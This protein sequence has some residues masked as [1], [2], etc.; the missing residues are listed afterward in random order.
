MLPAIVFVFSRKNVELCAHEI[1]TNLLEDDSKIPYIMRRECEQIVR[2]FPNFKEYL[3][4]PEYNELV[5][6]LEK[7]IGIHHSGMIPV[8]KEIC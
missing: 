8:L 4:L 2:K 1:T 7:G 5:G 6:L 3:E